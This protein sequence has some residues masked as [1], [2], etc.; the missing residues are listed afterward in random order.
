MS[1]SV[2]IGGGDARKADVVLRAGSVFAG[3]RLEARVGGHTGRTVYRAR[4]T[5]L[6][7]LVALKVI[8][9]M[10]A[11]DSL[12]RERLN[13]ELTLAA[14]LDHPNVVPIYDA[15]EHDDSIFVAARWVEGFDLAEVIRRE[16][17][18]P[19]PRAVELVGQV[20]A[21]LEVAHHHGLLHRDVKP[22]HVLVAP[23]GHAYLTGFGLTRHVSD[24]AGLT[25]PSALVGTLDHVAPEQ[26]EGGDIDARAD[27]YALG[28]LLFRTLTGEVPYRAL[29]PAAKL[30]AHLSPA[31]PTVR[32]QRPDV[33][34]ALSDVILAAMERDR[35]RR[36][37]SAA[38][39][40]SA[41]VGAV[42]A[43]RAPPSLEAAPP[44]VLED[45]V[46]PAGGGSDGIDVR[47]HDD[48]SAQRREPAE[49]D[50][51]HRLRPRG[52]SARA[53]AAE[54]PPH[55]P[56][57]PADGVEPPRDGAELP[58]DPAEPAAHPAD[59][60]LPPDAGSG[61]G[62]PGRYVVYGRG[63]GP[64]VGRPQRAGPR[65]SAPGRPRRPA[66]ALAVLAVIAAL[67]I[68]P[69]ALYVALR[70]RRAGPQTVSGATAASAL[71]AVGS[72]IWLAS[73]SQSAL[74]G[75]ADANPA[76]MHRRIGLGLRPDLLAGGG[77]L[78]VAAAGSQLVTLSPAAAGPQRRVS[79]PGSAVAIATRDG[80]TTWV[81]LRG[82]AALMRVTDSR[83]VRVRL[84]GV[85]G[86]VAIG[87]RLLW[88]ALPGQGEVLALDATTGRPFG[89]VVRVG[90]TPTALAVN[91]HSVW[92]ADRTR[93]V[94]LRVDSKTHRLT[95]PPTPVSGAPVA[96]AA[97]DRDVWVARRVANSATRLDA[98]T[99]QPRDE[100][101]VARAP[102][103]V[104]L[105]PV[106][107]WFVGAYGQL[108]RIARN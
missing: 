3:Y 25:A 76:A 74:V 21:A 48:A 96:L 101:G 30:M 84:P 104:T 16:H 37:A 44:D 34:L 53:F 86:A 66:R 91:T 71:T 14:S 47:H 32:E 103:G 73:P 46:A 69:A 15:G 24:P 41:I 57:L 4:D 55:A 77:A 51:G 93:G 35:E 94:V 52:E 10:H 28:C 50:A 49:G 43:T 72:T 63:R 98:R 29:E 22:S 23:D 99:G 26:I 42:G 90:A 59:D 82:Q 65:G 38:A 27:V 17:P 1:L 20:A 58:A 62:G 67:I 13:R 45:P 33:P 68:A 31:T 12:T 18:L 39:F 87:R 61:T 54:L 36:P 40:A 97:D 9:P 60:R 107:A 102:V 95:G 100:V 81:A 64:R 85:P 70:D 89:G 5:R 79:L 8:A 83:Q 6:G 19:V 106:A 11:S 108:T 105:T 80:H 88:V 78:L 92:V 56:E 75:V 2:Q 7:R